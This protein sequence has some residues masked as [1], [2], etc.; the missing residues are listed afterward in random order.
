MVA[1]QACA[2]VQFTKRSAAEIAAQK[3]FNKLFIKGRKLTIRW[4]KSQGKMQDSSAEGGSNVPGLPMALP[5]PPEEL[6]NNFFNF[7]TEVK[8]FDDAPGPSGTKAG[9]SAPPL[10]G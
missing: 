8:G 1:K 5:A 6:K 7:P 2:F 3:S 9:A 4:G 10:Q